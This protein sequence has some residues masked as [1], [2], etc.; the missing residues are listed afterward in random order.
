MFG[1]SQSVLLKNTSTQ[2]TTVV[3]RVKEDRYV[4]AYLKTHIITLGHCSEFAYKSNLPENFK[5]NH[6]NI[7]L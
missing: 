5:M 2:E 3:W 1:K 4:F 6:L 7:Q